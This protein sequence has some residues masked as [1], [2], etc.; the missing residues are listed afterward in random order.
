MEC[1]S[2]KVLKTLLGLLSTS[3]GWFIHSYTKFIASKKAIVNIQNFDDNN[4]FQYSVLA[5]MNVIKSGLRDHK[6]RPSSY[7]PYMHLLN[8]NGIQ[9]PV[10]LSAIDKFENQNPEISVN[11][12]YMNNRDIVPFAHQNFVT[13]ESTT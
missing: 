13:N 9:T 5:G 2:D 1:I 6:H 8:M 12:L 3:D 10:P 7:K 11:I 4:C